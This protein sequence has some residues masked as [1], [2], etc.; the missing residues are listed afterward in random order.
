MTIHT[1]RNLITVTDWKL[2]E[3]GV[4]VSYTRADQ[5][6]KQLHCIIEPADVLRGLSCHASI[7][8]YSENPLQAIEGACTYRW[9]YFST[10]Y[11]LSQWDAHCLVTDVV[12]SMEISKEMEGLELDT[13]IK[14]LKNS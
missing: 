12:L 6:E 8:D 9:E 14:A 4:T 1:L 13:I 11:N 5:K 7:D 10:H 3:L 2:T